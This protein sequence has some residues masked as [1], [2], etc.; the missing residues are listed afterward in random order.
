MVLRRKSSGG[1]ANRG[2]GNETC[3]ILQYNSPVQQGRG[4]EGGILKGHL[5]VRTILLA[6]HD[7]GKKERNDRRRENNLSG[8]E[9]IGKY[10]ENKREGGGRGK[11]GGSN[12]RAGIDYPGK[13]RGS[14]GSLGGGLVGRTEISYRGAMKD[15]SSNTGNRVQVQPAREGKQRCKHPHHARRVIS[16]TLLK[17]GGTMSKELARHRVCDCRPMVAENV[18]VSRKRAGRRGPEEIRTA[19]PGSRRRGKAFPLRV[20]ERGRGE[21]AFWM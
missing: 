3:N 13:G 1:G 10:I 21:G 11:K 8:R 16:F 17:G 12:K 2:G 7:R 15:A 9:K 14:E 20:R 4:G 19:T 18:L 6:K 5:Q